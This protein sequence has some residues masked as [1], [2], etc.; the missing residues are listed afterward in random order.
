MNEIQHEH[1]MHTTCRQLMLC[2]TLAKYICMAQASGHLTIDQAASQT[3]AEQS[4]RACLCRFPHK[5]QGEDS[6]L[7]QEGDVQ[8]GGSTALAAALEQGL[9]RVCLTQHC[10]EAALPVQALVRH[11]HRLHPQHVSDQAQKHPSV[12]M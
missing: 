5:G 7:V 1:H 2:A 9:S 4:E 11:P 6:R 3:K 10:L 12:L 8:Q